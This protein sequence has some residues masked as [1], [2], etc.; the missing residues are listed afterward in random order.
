MLPETISITI[1]MYCYGYEFMKGALEAGNEV[2][3]DFSERQNSLSLY[4]VQCLQYVWQTL[5]AER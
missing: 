2:E 4:G 5:S 1:K 3:K